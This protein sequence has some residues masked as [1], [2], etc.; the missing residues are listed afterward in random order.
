MTCDLCGKKEAAVH[1][2]EIVND[3]SRELH[4]CES[5]AREKGPPEIQDFALAGLLAGLA[6][7]G[8]KL[9]GGAPLRL[10]CPRCKMT[11]ED[12]RKGGRLGCG[13]C[14]ETFRRY[15][16]PLLK[17]IHGST[18]HVGKRPE[19]GKAP[20]R[21]SGAKGT[22]TPAAELSRLKEQLAKA[23]ASE[24]FEEAT[25]LRDQIR[26]LEAKVKRG[27]TPKGSKGV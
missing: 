1:L 16:A 11:H 7:F 19:F 2:T 5:C 15:L 9:E 24:Q 25:R 20:A 6:D 22:E 3:Q 4:L 14:Y 23:V 18:Q 26:A 12:F 13:D 27:Q 21:A 10:A 17:R 8:T